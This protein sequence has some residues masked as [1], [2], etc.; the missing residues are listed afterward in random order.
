MRTIVSFCWRT[1]DATQC[2]NEWWRAL[3]L[4]WHWTTM[5]TLHNVWTWIWH[6][7]GSWMER[8]VGLQDVPQAKPSILGLYVDRS[9]GCEMTN[10]WGQQYLRIERMGFGLNGV[11]WNSIIYL[12]TQRWIAAAAAAAAGVVNHL[13]LFL[14]VPVSRS[15]SLMHIVFSYFIYISLY[16]HYKLYINKINVLL[17]HCKVALS[18]QRIKPET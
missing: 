5:R 9:K 15:S 7:I 6:H 16:F 14:Q 10:N 13:N 12:C 3:N 17:L 11:P 4:G 1:R 18:T 8:S 2:I